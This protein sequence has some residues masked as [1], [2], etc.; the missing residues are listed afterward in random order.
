MRDRIK[1]QFASHEVCGSAGGG[2]ARAGEGAA[3]PEGSERAFLKARKGKVDLDSG[4]GK[5]KRVQGG[6]GGYYCEVCE[7]SLRDSVAYLD[8]ING[9]KHQR[10]LGF[11]MRVASSTVADVKARLASRKR[12][13]CPVSAARRPP[14]SRRSEGST[15]N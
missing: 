12:A 3:G 6:D 15:G 11:S 10:K 5:I 2:E 9:K 8:H 1:Y 4:A 7:C 14:H 13:W